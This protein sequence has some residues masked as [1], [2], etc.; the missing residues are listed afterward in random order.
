[1]FSRP[2]YDARFTI[3]S[4]TRT[5][6]FGLKADAARTP[7]PDKGDWVGRSL[8]DL[9]ADAEALPRLASIVVLDVEETRNPVVLSLRQVHRVDFPFAVEALHDDFRLGL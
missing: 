4:P 3:W 2:A 9:S 6:S 5:L 7:Q 8:R 1:M